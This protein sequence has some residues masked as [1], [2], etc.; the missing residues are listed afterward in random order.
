MWFCSSGSAVLLERLW[1]AH[2]RPPEEVCDADS[3]FQRIHDVN[4]HYKKFLST[5]DADKP[6]D[7]DV[8]MCLSHG[9]GANTYSYEYALLGL[10]AKRMRGTFLAFDSVGFGLTERPKRIYEYTFDNIGKLMMGLRN[11]EYSKLQLNE[12]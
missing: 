6:I 11:Y 1:Q 8:I 10:L 12:G 9:F 4:V 2:L 5:P 3:L 7:R